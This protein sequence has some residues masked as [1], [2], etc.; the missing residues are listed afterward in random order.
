M[1]TTPKTIAAAVTAMLALLLSGCLLQPGSFT[2]QLTVLRDGTF[3]YS[4]RGEIQA[5]SMNALMKMGA[6]AD[7]AEF[8]ATCY[9]DDYEE[10]ECTDQEAEQQRAES[11]EENEQMLG[12]MS[13]MMPG[14]DPGDPESVAKFIAML[15]EQRGWNSVRDMGDGIFMVDFAITSRTDRGFVFPILEQVGYIDPFV[16][17]TTTKDGRVRVK[18]PGFSMQ[19]SGGAMGMMAGLGALGSADSEDEDNPFA[20]I[21]PISGT[22]RVATDG[23][24]LTNNTTDGAMREGALRV[25]EWPINKDQAAVPET[26][27][28]LD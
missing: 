6:E 25:L 22:F 8:E 5:L 3:T 21:K 26:L 13:Q 20:A 19:E 18:A 24:I 10:R 12:M 15:E 27:I 1:T 4:Y 17:M 14:L 2:S 9:D 16:I 7:N 11:V 28:R 23:E